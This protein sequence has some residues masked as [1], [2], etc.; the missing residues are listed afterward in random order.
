MDEKA[1]VLYLTSPTDNSITR[2][3]GSTVETVLTDPRLRWPG[4]FS[5]G[6]D[7]RMYVTA[8]R[9]QDTAWFTPGAPSA[10]K[11]QLFSFTSAA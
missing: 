8:S 2:L 4:T 5:E 3:T 11:T 10:V 9:I 1:G 7:G 6:P